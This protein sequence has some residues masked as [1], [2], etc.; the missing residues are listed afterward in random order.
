MLIPGSV[1]VC[2]EFGTEVLNLAERFQTLVF[3]MLDLDL[4]MNNWMTEPFKMPT[5]PLDRGKVLDAKG[6]DEV[7]EFARYRD[8]DGD[9]IPYRTL[10]GTPHARAGFFTRGTG[11]TDRATY[12]EKP[13]DWQGNMDRLTRKFNTART[14][15][16]KPII[17]EVKGAKAAIIA[18]GSSDP[19]ISEAR[20]RLADEL[21]IKTDYMRMRALPTSEEVR[22][23]I[24][25]RETVY[26]VEQNRDAQMASILRA[27]YP[28]LAPKI[29]SILHYNGIPLD[30]Q[31][32]IDGIT[33]GLEHEKKP[34]TDGWKPWMF[35]QVFAG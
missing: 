1:E 32:I 23:F 11:H 9:G 7:Q 19:A 16:P 3:L 35:A 27:E 20:V 12:S 24:A 21:D 30:A 6:L 29:A 31:T 10:P 4:G 34:R 8:V 2:Y 5:K 26:V 13:E 33:G 18:Y 28:E 14:V 15:V 22:Q 17:D 25:S